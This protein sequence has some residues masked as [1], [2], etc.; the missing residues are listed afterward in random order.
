MLNGIF[1]EGMQKHHNITI[2]RHPGATTRDIVD[3]VKL[4]IRKKPD[5]LIIHAGTNDL[6]NREGVNT[7][8]NFK[9]IIKQTMQVSPDTTVVLS[10]VVIRIDQLASQ[11]K[12]IVPNLNKEIKELTNEMKTAFIDNG[13]P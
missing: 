2:K 3:Y 8:E 5:C 13:R 10:S 12:V 11:K 4:V 6:T 7:I 1:D 9:M